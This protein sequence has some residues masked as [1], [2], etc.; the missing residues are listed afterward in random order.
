VKY[1]GQ[2]CNP[3]A[4]RVPRSMYILTAI[5]SAILAGLFIGVLV[6]PSLFW[7]QMLWPYFWGPVVA[8]AMGTTVSGIQEGYNIVNT[9]IYG[10]ILGL[11]LYWIYVLLRKLEIE[12]DWRLTLA[13]TPHMLLGG[14]LRAL[15]DAGAFTTSAAYFF[16]SP[17]IYLTIAFMAVSSLAATWLFLKRLHIPT[18]NLPTMKE[19]RGLLLLIISIGVLFFLAIL[20]A[21]AMTVQTSSMILPLVLISAIS[22]VVSRIPPLR[23]PVDGTGYLAILASNGSFIFM[24]SAMYIL[25]WLD[26]PTMPG[27]ITRPGEA[28]IIPLLA[29]GAVSAATAGFWVLSKKLKAASIYLL[30]SSILI[31]SGHMLD[32]SATFRGVAEYGYTEKHVLARLVIDMA[33]S[34][35]AM[36]IMKL[37]I[38][39]AV[40]YVLE[41]HIKDELKDR[42]LMG[43]LRL[44]VFILGVGPGLR[45][46]LRITMGV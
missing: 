13:L 4:Y 27:V 31:M 40:V 7:D 1:G 12:V 32:A 17:M 25:F 37:A 28:F 43:I 11:A 26:Q 30:P 3:M 23:D 19:D 14:T 8:D 33:N 39:M 24:V 44:A 22:F 34:P 29:I 9:L 10:L 15:E 18:L 16:I 21:G 35:A 6:F 46:L 38:V 2:F 45:G 42:T 20:S 36:F 5:S 41:V